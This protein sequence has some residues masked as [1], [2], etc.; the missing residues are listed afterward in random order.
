LNKQDRGE[1]ME[2]DLF[3]DF[4]IDIKDVEEDVRRDLDIS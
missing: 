3:K 1:R 4:G 2:E